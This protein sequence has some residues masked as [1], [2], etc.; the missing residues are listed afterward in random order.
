MNRSPSIEK[1]L[2]LIS[3]AMGGSRSPGKCAACPR[4]FDPKEEFTDG[5]SRKEYEI[6]NLCQQCQ[7]SVFS[8]TLLTVF[9]LMLFLGGAAVGLLGLAVVKVN[10]PA[11]VDGLCNPR[12]VDCR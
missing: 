5:L 4:E 2:D 7:N 8:T 3:E 10:A 12:A 9:A 11:L 1:T 6:S